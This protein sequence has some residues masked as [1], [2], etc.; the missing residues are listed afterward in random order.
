MTDLISCS[1]S[2]VLLA[3]IAVGQYPLL[4]FSPYHHITPD[5]VR[6]LV[7]PCGVWLKR[8]KEWTERTERNGTDIRELIV[9]DGR[10]GARFLV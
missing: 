4:P 2:K 3:A 6:A 10:G 7:P 5:H 8:L 9:D 1:S